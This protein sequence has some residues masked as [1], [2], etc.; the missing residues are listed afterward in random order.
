MTD[1]IKN[2]ERCGLF[3][4]MGLGKTVTCLTAIDDMMYDELRISRVLIL[5]P[6]RVALLTWP[7]EIEKWSHTRRLSYQVIYDDNR[8]TGLETD[9]DIH[10]MSYSTL[11]WLVEYLREHKYFPFDYDMVIFDE[12]TYIKTKRSNR[13]TICNALFYDVPHKVILTGTPAPN[14]LH[15]LWGQIFHLDHGQSLGS[16]LTDFR[17]MYFLRDGHKYHPLK[18]AKAQIS[19]QL[20]HLVMPMKAKDYLSLP[21]FVTNVVKTLMPKADF[22]TYKQLEADFFL[23]IDGKEVSAFDAA[24][25]SMKLRQ[26]VQGFLISDDEGTIANVHS[27]KLD[28]LEDIINN[29]DDNVL[30]AVQF[31]HDIDMIRGRLGQVPAVYGG[32]DIKDDMVNI[33]KWN[34]RQLG[35]LVAHPASLAHG[36][37][38]QSGGS[39]IIWYG[40]PWNLEHYLQFNKRLHRSG[41]KRA[42]IAHHI[43]MDQTIDRLVMSVLRRK[44]QT[45]ETLMSDI[46]DYRRAV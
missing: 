21:P 11:P 9:A 24:S 41:Q 46:K 16:N 39:T 34:R 25:L 23:Q 6:L 17:R 28:V 31:R 19:K 12:S 37:N 43:V 8:Q 36:V 22:D 45:Q 20:A 1:F 5:A 26:F 33:G 7:D 4:E 32:T 40:I 42:V 29:T 14:G 27:L 18:N 2:R 38:L 44:E 13:W 10:I 35:V 30:I 15:D 3:A